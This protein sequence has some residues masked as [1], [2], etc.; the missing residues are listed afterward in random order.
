MLRSI[1][2]GMI[3]RSPTLFTLRHRMSMLPATMGG[4][5]KSAQRS[6]SQHG[7]DGRLVVEL[8]DVLTTGYYVDIGANHPAVLSNTYRLYCMGMRGICVE[9]N[10]LLCGL[11]ERYRPGDTIISAAVGEEDGL[12]PFY[13]MSYHAFNTF[14]EADYKRYIADGKM[15]LIRK[16][17]KPL[18]R[19]STILKSCA[20]ADKKFELLSVD[21]EGMDEQVLRSN[22]WSRWRPRFVLAEGNSDE[23]AKGTGAFLK[24]TGYERIGTF[25]VN[26]LYRDLKS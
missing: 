2:R 7:E 4:A 24:E 13:E 9:P 17:L 26:A 18:F 19:L 11:H 5:E 1:L 14:S 15:T 23:A 21:V 3:N 16:S 12:L 22:D 10:A 8:K 6:W 25:G 20:P